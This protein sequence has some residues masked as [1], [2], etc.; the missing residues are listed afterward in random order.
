MA[1]RAE[2]AIMV[3]TERDHGTVHETNVGKV[4]TIRLR[5]NPTTGYVWAIQTTNGLETTG[6]T[7]DPGHAI[8]EEGTRRFTFRVATVG[9]YHVRLLNCREWEDDPEASAAGDFKATIIA[10]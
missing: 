8:G 10:R 9:T 1:V 6:D 7:R 5:E 3:L 2:E 4:I